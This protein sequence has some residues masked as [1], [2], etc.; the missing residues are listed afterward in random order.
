IPATCRTGNSTLRC[1]SFSS[2]N[3]IYLELLYQYGFVGRIHLLNHHDFNQFVHNE[4]SIT[5]TP[6]EIN[7]D[8]SGVK[9]LLKHMIE[10]LDINKPQQQDQELPH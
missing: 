7:E 5:P 8:W 3:I 6:K 1:L 9:P 4:Y 2:C 10:E